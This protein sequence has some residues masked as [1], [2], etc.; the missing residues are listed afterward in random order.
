[1]NNKE[2]TTALAK[3][4]AWAFRRGFEICK[5]YGIDAYIH[6]EKHIVYNSKIKSKKNQYKVDQTNY[7]LMK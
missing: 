4:E 7:F 2:Y 5:G 3:L 6:E 1:M